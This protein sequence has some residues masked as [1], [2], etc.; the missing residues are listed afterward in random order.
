VSIT[1]NVAATSLP[2]NEHFSTV[3][4]PTAK[5]V[6][7]GVSFTPGTQPTNDGV[8]CTG[9]T[10]DEST[11]IPGGANASAGSACTDGNDGRRKR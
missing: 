10:H 4:A 6:V 9:K 2:K 5:T 8:T 3:V 11:N 1:D 7:R